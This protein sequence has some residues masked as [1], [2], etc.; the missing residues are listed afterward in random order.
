MKHIKRNNEKNYLTRFNLFLQPDEFKNYDN[1]VQLSLALPTLSVLCIKF[2]HYITVTASPNQLTAS[3]FI[4]C[5]GYYTYIH[6]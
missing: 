5:V 4:M 3:Y 6:I 1:L 2:S